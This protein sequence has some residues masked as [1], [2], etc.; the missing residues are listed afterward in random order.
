VGQQVNFPKQS[1]RLIPELISEIEGSI[2]TRIAPP[3]WREADQ[4][5]LQVKGNTA[6]AW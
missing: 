6:A 3:G 5:E 4:I 2:Q 1:R